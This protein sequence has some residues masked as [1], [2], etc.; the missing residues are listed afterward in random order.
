MSLLQLR[1]KVTK[2]KK[3]DLQFFWLISHYKGHIVGFMWHW[4][5]VCSLLRRLHKS[6]RTHEQYYV[7]CVIHVWEWITCSSYDASCLF[8]ETTQL[9]D[10]RFSWW[11]RGWYKSSGMLHGVDG[12]I[13]IR[14]ISEECG[15]S[16]YMI[17]PVIAMEDRISL[18]FLIFF[19]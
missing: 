2:H 1:F 14:D 6:Q 18:C 19:Y 11:Y 10:L 5:S 7:I 13:V 8:K 17:K 9:R 15:A 3:T 4:L 12:Q 16:I